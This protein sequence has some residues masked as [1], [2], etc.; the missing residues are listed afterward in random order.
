M[1]TDQQKRCRQD[2][3]VQ[4]M[5]NRL[6]GAS[7]GRGYSKDGADDEGVLRELCG[8]AADMIRKL[9]GQKA[10]CKTR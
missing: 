10:R 3:A 4:M 7:I 5:L 8:V 6:D 9:F 2:E 1:N